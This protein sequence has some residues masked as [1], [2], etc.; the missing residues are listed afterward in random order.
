MSGGRAGRV[1]C[2]KRAP[3]NS[4]AS[5]P[6]RGHGAFRVFD[7]SSRVQEPSRSFP[8]FVS[9]RAHGPKP[10]SSRLR[11]PAR[12]KPVGQGHEKNGTAGSIPPPSE[13][14]RSEPGASGEGGPRRS[15]KGG[16][17]VGGVNL[18]ADATADNRSSA[19]LCNAQ[20][21]AAERGPP[22]VRALRARPPSPLALGS[23]RSPSL[24]G[25]INPRDRYGP[26]PKAMSPR[27]GSSGHSCDVSWKRSSSSPGDLFARSLRQER[28]TR[29]TTRS[30][31][32]VDL[33]E[34]PAL[35]GHV[36]PDSTAKAG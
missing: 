31:R 21:V 28:G 30:R 36:H 25:G 20:R 12:S 14:E 17:V 10:Q 32:F 5:V 33:I 6:T 11:Y 35:D 24:G 3:A 29:E 7:R 16:G 9:Y 4:G 15:P 26:T 19:G 23:L 27:R 2:A 13:G 34:E 1:G 18:E 8:K 22:P